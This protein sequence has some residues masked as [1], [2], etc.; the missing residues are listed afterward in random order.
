MT[1]NNFLPDGPVVAWYGD[2]FT[3]SSAV[4]EALT[5]AGLPSV[6]FFNLPTQAQLQKF[7]NVKGVGIASTART[8]SPKWMEEHLPFALK[9]L[10][11]LSNGIVHYKVCTTMDSSPEIGSIG[12]A[13][14][15]GATTLNT[16]CV[17]ILIAAPQ[18]QRY[19]CFGN[20]FAGIGDNV[21]RI[22]RHPV[23]SRHPVTPILEADVAKHL[24]LQTDQV[25]FHSIHID[26]LHNSEIALEQYLP[27]P[28]ESI[29]GITIDCVDEMSEAAAGALIW[30]GRKQNRFVVG[31]QGV[32]YALIRHFKNQGQLDAAPAF[33]GIG[34]ADRT[35]IVSGSVSPIT[36]QQIDWS[37]DN[38]FDCIQF[39]AAAVCGNKNDLKREVEK[40]FNAALKAIDEG[41]DPLIYSVNG[42][43]DLL[44]AR[45]YNAVEQS[46]L[47]P[48]AANQRVGE[49]LGEILIRVID[50]TDIRRI[51]VSGGDTSGYA[52]QKLDLFALTALSPTI[53]GAAIF[54]TH[55]EN[56]FD[57]LELALKGGQMGTTD[58]FGWIRD[59]GGVR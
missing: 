3:G 11:E 29:S 14:E 10:S 20:L 32:E 38:N 39:D 53:P 19:Q 9:T 1:I 15:V 33:T 12:K 31:S 55:A 26:Q 17:P 44:V 22:D 41:K 50:E 42:P 24:E 35:V 56:R 54:R 28:N 37:R 6:L 49:A 46:G 59:G 57:G 16:N 27:E 21:Y 36:A 8:Q 51:V 18:M 45:F 30:N 47:D 25:A 4:M 2:D 48:S 13:I 43:D 5:F 52:T 58:Y 40:V 7:P 23:M 34:R